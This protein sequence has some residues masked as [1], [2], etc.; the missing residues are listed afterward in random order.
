[1]ARAYPLGNKPHVL[2]PIVPFLLLNDPFITGTHNASSLF[3]ML[4]AMERTL[5]DWY[6]HVK[7]VT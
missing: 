3:V 6:N 1:M 2:F 7:G 4:S 5:Y